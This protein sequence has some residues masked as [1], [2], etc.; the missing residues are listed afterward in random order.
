MRPSFAGSR[1][2]EA[3]A[4][5]RQAAWRNGMRRVVM[6]GSACEEGRIL[7]PDQG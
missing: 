5:I 6:Q 4:R 2:I 7:H 3:R 1:S